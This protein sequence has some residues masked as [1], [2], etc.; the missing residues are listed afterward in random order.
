[1]SEKGADAQKQGTARGLECIFGDLEP[2]EQRVAEI[3]R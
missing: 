3:R 2:S 1:M